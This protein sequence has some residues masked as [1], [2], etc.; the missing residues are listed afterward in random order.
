MAAVMEYSGEDEHGQ[1][2]IILAKPGDVVSKRWFVVNKGNIQWPEFTKIICQNRDGDVEIPEI[3]FS[4][5][6]GESLEL[7]VSIK[8]SEINKSNHVEM[9]IFRFWTEKYEYFGEPLVATIEVAPHEV[10]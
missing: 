1:E 2:F 5:L 3:D 9:Y 8:I 10:S 4:L 7:T 6:P